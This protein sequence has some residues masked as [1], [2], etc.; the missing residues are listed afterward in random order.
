[1]C[2]ACGP[3]PGHKALIKRLDDGV[4]A[5][6]YAEAV[7]HW[8]STPFVTEDETSLTAKWIENYTN[9]FSEVETA[10]GPVPVPPWR[11]VKEMTLTFDK[12]SGLLR[13]YK[14]EY[15]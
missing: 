14:V 9:D 5:M 11:F 3:S 4:G 15:R 13:N 8:G 10:E 6:T 2:V 1:M 12:S 7:K